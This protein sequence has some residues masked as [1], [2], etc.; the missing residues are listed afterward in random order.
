MH[1]LNARG[2]ARAVDL[3][4]E[5]REPAN[6][7]SFHLRQLAKYGLIEEAPER[8]RDGRDRWWK[9]VS[10]VGLS[11]SSTDLDAQPGGRAAMSVWRRAA[12]AWAHH[13]VERFYSKPGDADR[14]S[15]RTSADQTFRLTKDEAQKLTEE[16]NAVLDRWARRGRERD[17]S[18]G[19]GDRRTY[20]WL[21]YLQPY[22]DDLPLR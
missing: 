3:A 7:V 1:E 22:P 9:P 10:D 12:S 19:S 17:S 5:I 2:A 13:V 16:V 21:A 4:A 6:S 15:I 14:D 11:W 20:L 8:A 18:L